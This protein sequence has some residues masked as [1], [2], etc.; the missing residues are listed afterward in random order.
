M[1]G[2]GMVTIGVDTHKHTHVA[3]AIDGIG[4]RVGDLT[5]PTDHGGYEQLLE[6]ARSFGAVNRF[7]IEGTGSYGA[8]LVSYLRRHDQ[9][10][11]EAGRPDR[12]DRRQRGKSDTLDAENAARAALARNATAVPRRA[13]GTSEMLRQIKVAR[14]IAVKARTSTI[15][16]LKALIVT[17]PD[18]LR[19]ELQPLT[20]A[21]LRERCA[22][23]RPGPVTT[24]LAATKH[25]LRAL[26]R[27]WQ[28]LDAEIADH[29]EIVDELTQQAAPQ[30]REAFGIGPDIAAEMLILGGDRPRERLKSEAAFAM[31]CGAAPIPASS[32][33]KQRHRLNYG[34]HRQANSALYRAVIVRMRFHPA[35]IAYAKRRTEEGKTN[36]EI[37]RCLKRYLAREIYRHLT[38]LPEPAPVAAATTRQAQ[39]PA[40]SGSVAIMCGS[41][42]F[43]ITRNR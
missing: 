16:T 33:M 41:P 8:G 24:S 15:I 17:A 32:G 3:V 23:L 6:W 36:R 26:A 5:I 20:K 27:R 31:L 29:D 43:G 21:K 37:I 35:T 30:L 2:I 42:G 14:D 18:E 10:V 11:V 9:K 38:A 13:E 40:P 19:Q 25:S 1:A 39:P 34:G 7:G 22:G 28:M 4:E 12:R